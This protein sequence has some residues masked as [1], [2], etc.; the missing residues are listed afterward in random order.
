ML[1]GGGVGWYLAFSSSFFTLKSTESGR[2]STEMHSASNSTT[3]YTFGSLDAIVQWCARFNADPSRV[4]RCARVRVRGLSGIVVSQVSTRAGHSQHWLALGQWHQKGCFGRDVWAPFA[5]P[6]FSSIASHFSVV[7][8]TK[9]ADSSS[10]KDT[11]VTF[12]ET[13]VK[14]CKDQPQPVRIFE[15]LVSKHPFCAASSSQHVTFVSLPIS[16][17][18]FRAHFMCSALAFAHLPMSLKPGCV[19]QAPTR[20]M[21]HFCVASLRD[22]PCTIRHLQTL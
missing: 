3:T 22:V 17:F 15:R 20:R 12:Y 14:K 13:L 18:P 5:V 4:N 6:G 10:D 16:N 7:Q 21:V 8:H 9:M 19:R 11:F 2:H 1:L